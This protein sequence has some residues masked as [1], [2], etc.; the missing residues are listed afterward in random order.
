[1]LLHIRFSNNGTRIGNS[2]V[3]DEHL[4]WVIKALSKYGNKIMLPTDHM[5]SPA[6]DSQSV[7]LAKGDIPDGM[8]GFDIGVETSQQYSNLIASKTS[9]TT[10]WN[11]PMGLFEIK[12]F[13][14]GTIDI[15]KTMALKIWRGSKTLIGGGDIIRSDEK[16][17]SF[18]RRG[19]PRVY[20]WRHS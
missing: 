18:R 3:D 6:Q 2:P 11:G 10:F 7:S 20:W 16:S 17:R 19:K 12:H 5:V 14:N 8:I 13:A 9:G 4:P 15:A 1:M